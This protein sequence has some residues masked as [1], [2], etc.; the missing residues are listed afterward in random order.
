MNEAFRQI[1]RAGYLNDL[2]GYH[3]EGS[4]VEG[5]VD[6]SILPKLRADTRFHEG[7]LHSLHQDV[8]H[9][10]TEFRSHTGE[11]GDGSLQ[12]VI[13]LDDGSFYA[14]VDKFSPYAD[15]VGLFGHAGEVLSGW[16]KRMRA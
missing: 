16:W 14:D 6:L 3:V 12:F 1:H 5:I 9:H 8:G 11:F 4:R 2:V 10:R 7:P 15:V 13:C